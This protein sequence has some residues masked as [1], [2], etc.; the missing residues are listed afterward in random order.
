MFE[1]KRNFIASLFF[2]LMV[3][4]FAQP[5]MAQ[6]ETNSTFS[7]SLTTQEIRNFGDFTVQNALIRLPGVHVNRD[8]Q[9]SFRGTGYNNFYIM[10]NGQ[11]MS[12]TGQNKRLS[13][14]A[15]ISADVIQKIE[16]FK[17][18]SP[19]MDADGMAGAINL[20]TF[21][22]T[23]Y[24]SVTGSLGGGLNPEYLQE[25]GA[26]G[27]SWLRFTGPLSD[28]LSMA[29]DLNYQRDQRAWESLE[30]DYGVADIGNGPFDVIEELSP[31]FQ[32]KGE[33][34]FA[35][36]LQLDFTPNSSS[37][38]YFHSL[39][40]FNRQLRADH[41]Y[42]WVAN[43][44]W[45]DQNTA[46]SQ[47]G[48]RYDLDVEEW[49]TSQYTF[50][51][52][53]ENTFDN[54]TIDYKA[55]WAQSN[56]DRTEN[57]FPF[58][59]RGVEYSVSGV[60][61]NRP[62]ASVIDERPI[63]ADMDLQE[64]NYIIDDYRDKEISARLNV[65]IPF[66]FGSVKVGGNA[67]MKE[68]DAND[69]GAFSEYHY[70]FQG[71]LNLEGFE[72]GNLNSLNIFDNTYSLDRL[73]DPDNALSFF[74]SSIPNMRLDDRAY[75]RDSEIY[76][77]FTNEDIYAGYGMATFN[78]DP[79]TVLVGA[80]IE[81]TASSYEGRVVEYS[82]FGQFEA[83]S[84]TSASSDLTNVFPN[85][86]LK[87]ALNEQTNVKAAYS[88]TISRPEFNALAPFELLLPADTS[89][90]SGNPNLKPVMSDNIDVGVDY[91]FGGGGFVSISGFY[92]MMSDFIEPVTSDVQI[93]R[94]Q[95]T[96]FDPLI[97]DDENSVDG[98]STTF[99]NSSNTATVYGVEVALQKQF[100]S[101]PGVLQNVGT[102]INYTWSDSQF[103]NARGDET[104]LP[105]QS[106]HVVNA[107]LNYSQERFFA[108]VSYHWSDELLS[109]LGETTQLAPS[110]GAGEF[111]LDKYQDG[112]QELSASASF[113]ISEQVQ[114]WANIYNLLNVEY[115]EYANDRSNYPTSI[116]QRN[117][118]EFNIG[119][120]V[121]L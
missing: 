116:Y 28:D 17:V 66:D 89:I 4:I 80:R 51:A 69:R 70:T 38:Y 55:G 2:V 60:N 45:E 114:L 58:L 87:L 33:N 63:P 72:Q 84:D 68:Q 34:R 104:A 71:F 103:E 39:L 18:L 42:N 100:T 20:V 47:A 11:R 21:Q 53:G 19:D 26:T 25:T 64:M 54:F 8:G 65:E 15:A 12:A 16:W 92:K 37:R 77:Y 32:S 23:D 113:D 48:F 119:V 120:R 36:N 40:N 102:Y 52:G 101:L 46:G 24:T 61:T 43:E 85:A 41:T 22:P 56:V 74:Q 86:Q 59:A 99:Q 7:D 108:Q 90:F 31:G 67:L 76:N 106:P 10:V 44:D 109:Q 83:V 35:G 13:N 73:S 111:Y 97:D 107:A 82:R 121:S 105:G 94:G 6:T 98:Y 27:R 118:V 115:I 110:L 75:Y 30:M 78:F 9:V 3:S 91:N 29:M 1:K 79:L 49:N 95:Y 62:T 96:H 93:E 50:Q 5:L 88:R 117:G 112:F 57:L 81:H 14:P